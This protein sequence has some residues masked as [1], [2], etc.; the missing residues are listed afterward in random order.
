MKLVTGSGS[1]TI[2][3]ARKVIIN[4]KHDCE[5]S[6]VGT[7]CACLPVTS[8]CAVSVTIPVH[9]NTLQKMVDSFDTAIKSSE[10]Y[11]FGLA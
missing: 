1:I 8:V 6:T 10:L 4:F 3:G 2:G 9:A 5:D 11:G 7:K